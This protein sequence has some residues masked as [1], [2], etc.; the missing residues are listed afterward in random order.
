MGVMIIKMVSGEEILVKEETG[1]NVFS[2]PRV[3][4][5]MQDQSGEMRAGLVPW[6]ITAPDATV[7]ISKMAIA[8]ILDAPLDVEKSY[9]SSTSGIA[10]S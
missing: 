10:L 1:E 7:T 3:M 2:K 8:A 4:Q 5:V 6:I 9:L